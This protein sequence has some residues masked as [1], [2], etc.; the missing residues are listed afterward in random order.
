MRF[1]REQGR[2]L[3]EFGAGSLGLSLTFEHEG[4][5][6]GGRAQCGRL[7]DLVFES[8]SQRLEG[9]GFRLNV[10]SGKLGGP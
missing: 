3:V 4:S 1:S 6:V 2:D 7:K 8:G 5:V 10:E 9:E